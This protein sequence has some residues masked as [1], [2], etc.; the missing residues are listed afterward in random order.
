MKKIIFLLPLIIIGCTLRQKKHTSEFN[1]YFKQ[2]I[3]YDNRVELLENNIGYNYDLNKAK[4]I[5]IDGDKWC[6]I[7]INNHNNLS[8]IYFHMDSKEYISDESGNSYRNISK[9]QCFHFGSNRNTNIFSSRGFS[10]SYNPLHKTWFIQEGKF[11]GIG[12]Q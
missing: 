1:I 2:H 8:G 10:I 7:K 11:R 3:G 6:H 9:D 12:P 4:T 5:L